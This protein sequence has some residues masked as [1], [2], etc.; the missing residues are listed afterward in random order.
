VILEHFR[1]CLTCSGAFTR[2]GSLPRKR[3]RVQTEFAACAESTSAQS[4]SRE[5]VTTR[6]GARRP[7][8]CA[9]YRRLTASAAHTA[10]ELG[11]EVDHHRHG[12]P[13]RLVVGIKT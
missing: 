5:R 7:G 13:R 8:S 1:L 3:G 10:R 2:C 6:S 12:F 9:L 11:D 4:T